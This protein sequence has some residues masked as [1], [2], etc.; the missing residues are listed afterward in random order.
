MPS[1]K[2]TLPDLCAEFTYES[3]EEADRAFARLAYQDTERRIFG[4]H[5]RLTRREVTL[6]GGFGCP[7]TIRIWRQPSAKTPGPPH[8]GPS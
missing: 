7:F 4:S 6:S 8:A 1:S 2:E 3:R 5:G